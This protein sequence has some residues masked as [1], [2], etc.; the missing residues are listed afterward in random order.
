MWLLL[1]Q[2]QPG[3]SWWGLR[4]LMPEVLLL[5]PAQQGSCSP[6][7]LSVPTPRTWPGAG[8]AATA[9]AGPRSVPWGD[10]QSL[11]PHTA[12]PHLWEER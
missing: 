10:C 11:E 12:I 4:E 3:C 6:L 8:D 2:R 7:A 1:V 5:Y 9:G